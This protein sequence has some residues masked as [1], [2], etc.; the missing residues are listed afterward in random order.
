MNPPEVGED[1]YEKNIGPLTKKQLR[2]VRMLRVLIQKLGGRS[3]LVKLPS[4]E[5]FFTVVYKTEDWE[6]VKMG[7]MAL[8]QSMPMDAR[9]MQG[10][11]NGGAFSNPTSPFAQW[12]GNG[13]EEN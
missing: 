6:K 10:M 9:T 8:M 12:F 1:Q 13:K 11:S 7:V 3:K 4:G 2:N 5:Y